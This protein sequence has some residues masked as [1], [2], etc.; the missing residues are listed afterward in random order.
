M[1][2]IALPNI[3][4]AKS[5]S[6]GS[7]S[8]M[9][10][11]SSSLRTIGLSLSLIA[12]P[13]SSLD[14]RALISP[15]IKSGLD[16]VTLRNTSFLI[17]GSVRSAPSGNWLAIL[18]ARCLLGIDLPST[19]IASKLIS[20]NFALVASAASR[21]AGRA[22]ASLLSFG[23]IAIPGASESFDPADCAFFHLR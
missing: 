23:D 12:K 16:A 11:L 7:S 10:R 2:L 3:L 6:S 14:N 8:I 20:V 19:F 9:L 15:N 4:S 22:S 13:S 1:L 18:L 5:L 21:L 17:D